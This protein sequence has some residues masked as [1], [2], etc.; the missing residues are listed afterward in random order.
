[1][2]VGYLGPDAS[3]THTATKKTFLKEELVAFASI[4]KC[5]KAAETGLIDI[6]VV[7]IENSI[8]GTVNTTLDHL[9]H[10]STLPVRAEIVLPISQQLMVHK[11]DKDLWKKTKKILSH[12]QALAQCQIFIG[13]HFEDIEMEQTSST[14]FAASFVAK[15]PGAGL[16]AI[17]PRSSAE[18]YGLEIVA[19]DIQDIALNKTRFWVL[20]Q[21]PC[22]I[23][24][25]KDEEKISISVTMPNNMPGAL[26]KALSAFSWRQINLSKIE[27]RPLKTTLGEYFFLMDMLVEQPIELI[28]N[29]IEEI[30]LLGGTVKIFGDYFVYKIEAI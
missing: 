18:K 30:R 26:H 23:L 1:M 14:S 19:S 7:P 11:A 25:P 17:A 24:L 29:A 9:Y 2:K 21:I 16:A 20:S 5:I 8:E 10:Q 3:F 22:D 15:H 4:P 28:E 12:P 13:E 27:S 6:A